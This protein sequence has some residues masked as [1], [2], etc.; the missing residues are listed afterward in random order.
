MRKASM[1]RIGF[2]LIELLVVV[3]IIAVLVAILLPALSTARELARQATCSSNLRQLGLAQQFYMSDNNDFLTVAKVCDS[4]GTRWTV[5][6]ELDPYVHRDTHSRYSPG[7]SDFADVWT[8]PSRGSHQT[9]VGYTWSKGTV[10]WDDGISYP[11]HY[12]CNAKAMPPVGGTYTFTRK[13]IG[14]LLKP[15]STFLQ[16]DW[17]APWPGWGLYINWSSYAWFVWSNSSTPYI[18]DIHS[19]GINCLFGDFSVRN[20]NRNEVNSSMFSLE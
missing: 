19:G 4:S 20:Y 10:V 12:A 16:F 13:R 6:K 2:T 17:A 14:N 1:Y 7:V 15:S 11:M 5:L 8:C 3:A 18:A 9:F